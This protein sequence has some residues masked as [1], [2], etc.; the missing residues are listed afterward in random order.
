MTVYTVRTFDTLARVQNSINYMNHQEIVQSLPEDLGEKWDGVI[1]VNEDQ[2]VSVAKNELKKM[3]Y[4]RIQKTA[5]CYY[6]VE[7]VFVYA[8]DI[9]DDELEED[10]DPA[11]FCLFSDVVFFEIADCPLERARKWAKLSVEELADAS[12]VSTH[13]IYAYEEG[14]RNIRGASFMSIKKIADAIGVDADD[15]I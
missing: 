2:A 8:H 3:S 13:T 11:L 7:G 9:G 12:G 4:P 1:Y 15:I 6:E 5:L 14:K 10:D